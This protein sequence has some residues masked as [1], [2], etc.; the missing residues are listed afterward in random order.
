MHEYKVQFDV[1][2][3]IT[4]YDFKA[5]P[6]TNVFIVELEQCWRL[7]CD[8]ADQYFFGGFKKDDEFVLSNWEMIKVVPCPPEFTPC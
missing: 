6:G 2:K 7:P 4:W 1:D 5:Y 3:T 8:E